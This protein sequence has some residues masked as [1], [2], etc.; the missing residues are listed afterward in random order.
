M[1]TQVFIPSPQHASLHIHHK[2]K[3]TVYSIVPWGQEDV[4]FTAYIHNHPVPVQ[5][6]WRS[7]QEWPRAMSPKIK[8]H[9]KKTATTLEPLW[10]SASIVKMWRDIKPQIITLFHS[11]TF[12]RSIDC[13]QIPPRVLNFGPRFC[14]KSRLF[15]RLLT[16]SWSSDWQSLPFPSYSYWYGE[17]AGQSLCSSGKLLIFLSMCSARFLSVRAKLYVWGIW[18]L[19]FLKFSLSLWIVDQFCCGTLITPAPLGISWKL[20]W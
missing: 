15:P 14:R 19:S 16:V 9:S 5:V 8:N 12:L 10:S 1:Q 18:R 2:H 11:R 3:C 20:Y 17:Y 7:I 13:W 4:M 6:S